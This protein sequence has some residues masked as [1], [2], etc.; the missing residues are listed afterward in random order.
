MT[1]PAHGTLLKRGNAATPEVFTTIAEVRDIDG[2]GLKA[3]MKDVTHHSS[4]GFD[5][6]LPTTLTMGKV[7]CELG[8]DLSDATHSYTAGLIKDWK[9]KTKRNFQIV[10]PLL[11]PVTWAFSAYV[12][13]FAM[14]APVKG[15]FT[16]SLTLQIT[17][18][19]TLA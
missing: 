7:K 8:L 4:G 16:A 18:V 13:E 2:P 1:I 5:E 3:N 6:Y 15:D 14:K 9:L 11:A 12:E 19:P 17:G 10:F